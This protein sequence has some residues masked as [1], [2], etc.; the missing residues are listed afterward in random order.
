MTRGFKRTLSGKIVAKFDDVERG[1]IRHLALEVA[2][3]VAPPSSSN[4]DPLALELGLEDLDLNMDL[5]S[6]DLGQQRDPALDRLFPEA[7][8]DDDAAAMDF[9]R[10]TE[11][12]LRK[13]KTARLQTVVDCLAESGAKVTLTQAQALDWLGALN[14]IRLVMSVRMDLTT[15]ADHELIALLPPEDPKSDLYALYEYFSFVLESLTHAVDPQ[16]S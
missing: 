1:L 7:Y 14:D 11:V 3:M 6:L 15:A 16:L 10:F 2:E 4:V 12:S 5:S 9:R 13:Q 8:A